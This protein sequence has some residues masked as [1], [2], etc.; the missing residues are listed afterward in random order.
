MLVFSWSGSFM[1]EYCTTIR[2]AKTK[3]LISC[4]VIRHDGLLVSA[5]ERL[6]PWTS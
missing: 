2:L 6:Y 5:P 3:A 4:G 1:K